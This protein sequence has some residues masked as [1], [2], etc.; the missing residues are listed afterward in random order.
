MPPYKVPISHPMSRATGK[1]QLRQQSIVTFQLELLR[2][3]NG[4]VPKVWCTVRCIQACDIAM[5]SLSHPGMQHLPA[6]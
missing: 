1:V 4:P 2:T 6:N 5:Y 3:A